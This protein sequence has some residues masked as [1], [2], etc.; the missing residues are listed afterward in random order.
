MRLRGLPWRKVLERA[1]SQSV[2]PMCPGCCEGL[3]NC[4]AGRVEELGRIGP[5]WSCE[6][7]GREW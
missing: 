1:A 5:T 3:G 4:E 2:L 7:I 6:W